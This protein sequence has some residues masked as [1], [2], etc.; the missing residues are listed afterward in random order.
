MHDMDGLLIQIL[1]TCQKM[2][3]DGMTVGTWGNISVK[4]DDQHF[5]ITPSG[6]S[7]STLQVSDFV[8]MNMS[9][10][11]FDSCR[12]PSIE[13]LLHTRIYQARKDVK[14]IIHTHPQYSTAFAIARM[15]IP[16]VSEELVQI[17]GEG[18]KCAKYALPGTEDLANN[19]VEALEDRNAVLLAN[20]GAVCVSESLEKAY[21]I[22][23][24][25]EK[26]SQTIIYAKIIG[27]PYV[28]NHE[29]CLIMQ[30]FARN[31]YGQ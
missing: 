24:V 2:E 14:A 11:T 8:K 13:F 15:D 16:P 22:S 21:T 3:K 25:L 5:F 7:Y 17:I 10:Q 12:K 30:D 18:V 1:N 23:Q 29:E 31:K 9:G 20:H 28:I 4:I 26:S 27:T 6:M 19:A